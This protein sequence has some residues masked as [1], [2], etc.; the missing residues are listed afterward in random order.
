MCRAVLRFNRSPGGSP[1][2]EL[3][4]FPGCPPPLCAVSHHQGPRVG[5]DAHW[6]RHSGRPCFP[7]ALPSLGACLLSTRRGSLGP[8]S[9]ASE[10]VTRAVSQ[11]QPKPSHRAQEPK[12]GSKVCFLN[13]RREAREA[14]SSPQ[15]QRTRS[16][17]LL[18]WKTSPT[19]TT[20][21]AQRLPCPP[22]S[23]GML[24][25]SKAV[26]EN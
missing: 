26:R 5:R 22:P 7:G 13:V 20:V 14:P 18:L 21:L 6:A 15:Q 8:E 24:E 1:D 3:R 9:Q 25:A 19:P 12:K 11:K 4:R 16:C 17:C 10:D 23:L 2:S